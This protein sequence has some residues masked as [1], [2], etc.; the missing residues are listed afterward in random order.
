MAYAWAYDIKRA[1]KG[2]TRVA[3]DLYPKFPRRSWKSNAGC[4]FLAL[5]LWLTAASGL[6]AAAASM[7]LPLGLPA[8]PAPPDNPQTPQK[9]SLGKALFRDTRFSADEKIGCI[10]CHKPERAFTDGLAVAKGLR[11]QEGT[12][13]TPTLLN[14]GYLESQFWD[15]RRTGLEDQA[16]DPFV[17]P[18]EHGLA[19]HEIVLR[20]IRED[21]TYVS[22]F[23]EAFGVGPKA[24]ALSHVVMALANFER[25]LLA[26]GAPFDRYYYGGDKKALSPAAIRGFELFRG[27]ARCDTCHIVGAKDALFTDNRF[28]SLGIGREHIAPQLA[29]LTKRVVAAAPDEMDKLIFSQPDVAAL[30]R[31]VVTKKPADIGKFRTPS[32]RNVALT[33]PYM[34]D[35]SIATLEEVVEHELYY[36]GIAANRPLILTP[37]EK[38]DLVIFLKSLT[39]AN[40][41]R[42]D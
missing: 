13:N 22:A 12:R 30:G 40:L 29:Q 28:H 34:H 38:A 26:G 8:L 17:N 11:D 42:A 21:K 16:K 36:R 23:R 5:A 27:K 24:I 25:S 9:I 39:S 32:L 33:P 10:S 3:S 18:F 6:Y 41:P 4:T 7:S 2:S 15:G 20:K 37:Q 14:A 19:D 1:I 35:G 31:F